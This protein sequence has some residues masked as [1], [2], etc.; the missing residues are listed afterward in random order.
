MAEKDVDEI[1]EDVAQ[2]AESITGQQKHAEPQVDTYRSAQVSSN[3]QRNVFFLF[4]PARFS[5]KRKLK[6]HL[7]KKK[8][9]M[10]DE[11]FSTSYFWFRN[12]VQRSQGALTKIYFSDK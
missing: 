12:V 9:R 4:P 1:G 10:T 8:R 5:W 6:L 11:L 7:T 3:L 2:G